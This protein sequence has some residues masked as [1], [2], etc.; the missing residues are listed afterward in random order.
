MAELDVRARAACQ[1]VTQAEWELA[2][3]LSA[4]QQQG[5]WQELGCSSIVDY[6]ERRLGM[7]ADHMFSLL[8]LFADVERF[9]RAMEA[10]RSGEISRAKLREVVRVMTAESER[11]WLEF[12]RTH[13]CREVEKQVVLRPQQVKAS[14]QAGSATTQ[15]ATAASTLSALRQE[16][17]PQ[18]GQAKIEQPELPAPELESGQPAGE[19]GEL[20]TPVPQCGQPA[21]VQGELLTAVQQSEHHQGEFPPPV[22]VDQPQAPSTLAGAGNADENDTKVPSPKMVRLELTFAADEYAVIEAAVDLLRASGCGR[23]REALFVEMAQRVLANADARTRRRHAVVVEKD[24]NTGEVA[25]VTGRG[26]L[27]ARPAANASPQPGIANASPPGTEHERSAADRSDEG[28]SRGDSADSV[29]ATAATVHVAVEAPS[30]DGDTNVGAPADASTEIPP[31]QAAETRRRPIPAAVERAVLERAGYACERCGRRQGLQI[32]HIDRVCR[33]GTNDPARLAVLCRPY[34]SSE[35]HNEF[36]H[37]L[38]FILG[39]YA[40]VEA[41]TA[42]RTLSPEADTMASSYHVEMQ[43][44]DALRHC[45]NN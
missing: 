25:Y 20:L 2:Q 10:W 18:P 1:R 35:H 43:G 17:L 30:E 8:R 34:H 24:A 22:N 16:Q 19:R 28:T 6:A 15:T 9:P 3:L 45:R 39:R 31:P 38:T 4:M 33:G 21:G 7:P 27:P 5:D 37:D 36:E 42:D 32:H 26:Y 40:A 44:S 14:R 23:R 12:A 41:A 13:S 11:Q 29:A